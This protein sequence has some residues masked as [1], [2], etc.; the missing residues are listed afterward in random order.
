MK[1][2][3]FLYS[4]LLIMPKVPSLLTATRALQFHTHAENHMKFLS[5]IPWLIRFF[6]HWKKHWNKILSIFW[7]RF[8]KLELH[9]D[10]KLLS[11]FQNHAHLTRNCLYLSTLWKS[12]N[13]ELH[14]I[15]FFFQNRAIYKKSISIN[16]ISR[17]TVQR[18]T[19]LDYHCMCCCWLF[20]RQFLFL[21]SHRP[22]NENENIYP[23]L[24]SRTGERCVCP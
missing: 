9:V 2:G 11:D 8:H 17:P 13:K 15:P 10:I 12:R 1:P 23:A 4:P 22:N 3:E 20:T 19:M 6:P 24:A 18:K 5:D 16:D 14:F 21:C 7:H